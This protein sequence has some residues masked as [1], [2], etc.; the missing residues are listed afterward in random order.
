MIRQIQSLQN[1][2]K[3]LANRDKRYIPW[4]NY[5]YYC[6]FTEY[7]HKTKPVIDEEAMS[8]KQIR[9]LEEFYPQIM[10][11]KNV[12]S[13]QKIENPYSCLDIEILD[14]EKEMRSYILTCSSSMKGFTNDYL[15]VFKLSNKKDAAN[16]RDKND[17]LK[18]FI[19]RNQIKAALFTWYTRED[20]PA[21]P[22]QYH[23][24]SLKFRDDLFKKIFN[25]K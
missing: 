16:L 14:L 12:Y 18:T 4:F 19:T 9:L 24:L 3:Q 11:T 5:R 15:E 7:Y 8:P 23:M 2:K 13:G 25:Q 22:H 17:L 20:Y 6:N 1:L 10:F 21:T